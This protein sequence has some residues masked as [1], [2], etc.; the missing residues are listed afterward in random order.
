MDSRQ[1]LKLSRFLGLILRHQPERFGLAMDE[2]GWA[3][4]AEVMEVLRGLPNFRWAR[5]ADVLQIVEE[6][7]GDGKR[8]FEVNGERIRA[9]RHIAP[10]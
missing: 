9:C 2:E 7:S 1:A 3:S 5:R 10:R 8:R 6:G 4:L